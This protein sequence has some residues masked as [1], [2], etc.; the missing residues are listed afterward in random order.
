M[1]KGGE[2]MYLCLFLHSTDPPLETTTINK[3]II[4]SICVGQPLRL[5]ITLSWLL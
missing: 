1:I 4:G 5:G 2:G 3:G